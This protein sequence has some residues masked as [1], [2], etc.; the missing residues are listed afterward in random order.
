MPENSLSK[1]QWITFDGAEAPVV[2]KAFEAYDVKKAVIE[3][4]G[5][6][7]FYLFVNGKRVSDDLF[8]PAQTNYEPRSTA[9]FLYP[10]HDTMSCRIY[11]MEYDVTD[12]IRTGKNIMSVLIGNG[13]Y[14]QIDRDIEG[15]MSFGTPKLIYRICLTDKDGNTSNI[16]SDTTAKWENSF[17]LKNNLFFGEAWDLNLF[18]PNIHTLSFD[19]SGW[20]YAKKAPPSASPL[21]K[22][23]FPADRV[24]R[25]AEPKLI[26]EDNERKIYDVGENITG[27]MQVRL[28]GK[29][30]EAVSVVYS[31]KIIEDNRL[32]PDDGG[33][34]LQKDTFICD[35][36][37]QIVHPFFVFHAFRYCEI[38]GNAE[39]L[40]C[41]VIHTPLE[42][43]ADFKSDNQFLNWLYNVYIRTQ[44]DNVHMSVPLDC[45]HRE[46]LGYTGDGQ[47][48]AASAMSVFDGREFYKKWIR[49]IMDCQD[50]NSGHIQHS[51]PFNGGGGGP[52]GWG[53]AIVTVPYM[54]YKNY[55]DKSVLKESYP[56]MEKWVAYMLSKSEN[57]LVVREEEGGWCLGDW[58]SADTEN[59]PPEPF[60]NTYYL[61]K[62]LMRMEEICAALKIPFE[63]RGVVK[64]C[65]EAILNA[66]FDE[67]KHSFCDSRQG[68]DAFA[69]DIGLGD[70]IT[71]QNMVRRY[72][73]LGYLDTGI[74]ATEVLLR[75]L[76][77]TDHADTAL[78]L[79]TSTKGGIY[80][81]MKKQNATTL[82][83][84][85]LGYGSQNHPMFGSYA[86]MLFENLAGI[87][88]TCTGEIFIQPC[89]QSIVKNFE[90]SRQTPKGRITVIYKNNSFEIHAPDEI[91]EY[92]YDGKTYRI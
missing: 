13:W 15:K 9:D 83:E 20:R 60:V 5:L 53:C 43:T 77:E 3:I 23:T 27:W 71:V 12:L 68:A 81:D 32:A 38:I 91:K 34:Q 19:D 65:K 45:P 64:D 78:R 21:Q 35:G 66:Y 49:D 80:S 11:Y 92:S 39:A 40:I 72:E 67:E 26:F 74:F 85:R 54:H 25:T 62:S 48:T 7:N 30:N 82:W 56:A 73:E 42:I 86:A 22:Q 1:A 61:V 88:L 57:N 14:N 4:C 63:Y 84:H 70:E 89:R 24:I 46:R 10:I 51:A 36:S 87:K 75:A 55:G 8:V 76:F 50:I 6:G 79:L 59:L 2:R 16:L 58:S 90:I 18:D 52:G 31:E 69:V 28:S 29:K 47:I 33:G 37:V 44:T 41:D 17:I